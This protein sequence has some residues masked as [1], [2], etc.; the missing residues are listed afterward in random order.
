M[1]LAVMTD[2]RPPYIEFETR[3]QEDRN[4]SI[5]AGRMIYQDVHYVI[6]RIRGSQ[7]TTEKPVE[8]WL[9]QCE[10]KVRDGK[11]DPRWLDGFKYMYEQWKQGEEVTGDGTHIK[12]WAAITPAEAKN[13]QSA[14][15]HTIEDVSAMNEETMK[16]VGMGARRLKQLAADYLSGENKVAMEMDALRAKTETQ[17]AEMERLRDQIQEL[18]AALPRKPGRPR[19]VHDD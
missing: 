18:Q 17:E 13:L 11:M 8:A 16:R 15:V 6:V 2:E 12:N 3:A 14:L 9:A 4:A 7:N 10:K 19:K 5:E 1:S